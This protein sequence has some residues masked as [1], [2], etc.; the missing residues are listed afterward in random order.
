[1]MLRPKAVPDHQ[2]SKTPG[3]TENYSVISRMP[4]RG[5]RRRD[6]P[7]G[8]SRVTTLPAPITEREPI[9]TPGQRIAPPPTHTF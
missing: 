7:S 8:M 2:E 5:F 4:G 6:V 9:R 1:M 3:S